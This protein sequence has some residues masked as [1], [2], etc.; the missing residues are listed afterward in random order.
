MTPEPEDHA[1]RASSI[2]R[3]GLDVWVTYGKRLHD[4]SVTKPQWSPEDVI[5]DT[6]DLMEHLTPLVERS[7]QLSLDVL[8]PW[9]AKFEERSQDA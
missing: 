3:D 5:G 2:V 1:G 8:R 4:R 7:I 6:T 9:A